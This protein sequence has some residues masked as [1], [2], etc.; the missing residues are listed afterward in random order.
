MWRNQPELVLGEQ[1]VSGSDSSH[2]CS[3]ADV[4]VSSQTGVIF[5]AD[6]YCNS[7]IITFNRFGSYFGEFG[8]G[9][10]NPLSPILPFNVTHAVSL[11][12]PTCSKRYVPELIFVA[13][14]NNGRVQCFTENGTFLYEIGD[15]MFFQG[16]NKEMLTSLAFSSRNLEVCA[17]S[18][19][20]FGTLYVVNGH[21]PLGQPKIFELAVSSSTFSLI[22]S[23]S[24][25][26]SEIVNQVETI[27]RIQIPHDITVS[28]D[29]K[30]LYVI[31]AYDNLTVKKF[32]RGA[33]DFCGSGA[34]I[35]AFDKCNYG[36]IAFIS[37][38]TFTSGRLNKPTF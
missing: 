36:I 9:T 8:A 19:Q 33:E 31:E 27:P 12:K 2:F 32:K 37:F 1:F 26:E 30:S 35:I 21:L 13:D 23:I 28:R 4:A 24:I 6:G 20:T 18:N 29:G 7:R 22:D 34:S 11:A 38:I 10:S 14:R 25:S 17:E 16:I 3:P 15:E 5:I